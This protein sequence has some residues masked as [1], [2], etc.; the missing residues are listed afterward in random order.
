M[1]V[2]CLDDEDHREAHHGAAAN[3]LSASAPCSAQSNTTEAAI[4]N[5]LEDLV[6]VLET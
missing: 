5:I 1:L 6:F 2:E 4:T 3:S